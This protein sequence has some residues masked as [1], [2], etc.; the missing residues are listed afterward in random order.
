MMDTTQL[1]SDFSGL[2]IMPYIHWSVESRGICLINTSSGN[3]KYFHYP[4]AALWNLFIRGYAYPQILEMLSAIASVDKDKTA[5][6][7]MD[8]FNEWVENGFLIQDFN[9]G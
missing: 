9:H 8:T 5:I 2:S 4:Q 6:L 1:S 7:I 3:S